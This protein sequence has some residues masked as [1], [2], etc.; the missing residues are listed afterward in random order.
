MNTK[1]EGLED[2][3]EGLLHE[4][5]ER[6]KAVCDDL[7]KDVRP[8]YRVRGNATNN[9]TARSIFRFLLRI[10]HGMQCNNLFVPSFY[11]NIL[12]RSRNFLKCET[13]LELQ[14]KVSDPK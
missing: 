12:S 5:R 6:M 7:F 3:L 11:E 9:H 10:H 2:E 1:S 14:W 4:E 8:S 13:A